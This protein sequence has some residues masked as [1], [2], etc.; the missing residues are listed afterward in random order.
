MPPYWVGN[1]SA[2]M[3]WSA[4]SRRTSCGNSAERSISAARGATC[5]SAKTR[6]ASRSIA[7]SSVRR[8]GLE[9]S[10]PGLVAVSDTAGILASGG[11]ATGRL[12][13]GS[14][15]RPIRSSPRFDPRWSGLPLGTGAA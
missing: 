7:C 4:S 1:G 5:S 2:R 12:E 8:Y 15:R 11:F 6:T 10:D 3:S 9:W 14:T 13:S